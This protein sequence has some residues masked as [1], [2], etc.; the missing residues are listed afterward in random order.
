MVFFSFRQAIGFDASL[1]N[2]YLSGL[3]IHRH[4]GNGATSKTV[5]ID[6]LVNGETYS[7]LINGLSIT[8]LG[9]S[10]DSVSVE[11]AFSTTCT[12]NTPTVNLAPQSQTALA[13]S[14]VSYTLNITNNDTASCPDSNWTLATNVP[15][16]WPGSLSSSGATISPGGSTTINWQATSSNTAT[17]GDYSLTADLMDS[18]TIIHD[19]S[20]SANYTV[21]TPSDTQP[22]TKPLGLTASLQRKKV[23]VS[24]QPSSDN[25][26]VAGYQIFRNDILI[27][28]TA[29]TS[30]SDYNL[31][32]GQT[33]T[34]KAVA[35]DAANNYSM[36][37]NSSS[38][39]YGSTGNGNKGR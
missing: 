10:Q 11:V 36:I 37:S 35:F 21:T 32:S 12:R 34:Y 14:T 3:S 19:S 20:V 7:D 5:W 31:N 9:Y 38:V 28:T 25:I 13:G 4:A 1:S 22:P 17:D 27:A 26:A 18:A 23:F 6:T 29:S 16:G 15:A 39:T 33:Y 30:Y 2:T 8:Q 24:W